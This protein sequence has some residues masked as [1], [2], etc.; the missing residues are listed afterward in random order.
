MSSEKEVGAFLQDFKEKMKL[1]DVLFRDD[2]G[3]NAK[4]LLDL[5]LRPIDRKTVLET[6]EIR[7][8][9]EG[10]NK[11]QLYGGGLTFGFSGKP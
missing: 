3:K 11:D 5:E 6:L 9:S 7:D 4:A 1:R 10:P 2:R 8:Y